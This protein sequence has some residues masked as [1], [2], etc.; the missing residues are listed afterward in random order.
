MIFPSVFCNS[1]CVS[2]EELCE[3]PQPQQQPQP[4]EEMSREFKD[5]I[6]P[7]IATVA[8]LS[9]FSTTTAD[10]TATATATTRRT[11]LWLVALRLDNASNTKD[12]ATRDRLQRHNK[13]A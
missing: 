4:Q 10:T 9:S 6:N 5:D 11:N 1:R 12:R 13:I 8:A 3:G 2:L 7:S